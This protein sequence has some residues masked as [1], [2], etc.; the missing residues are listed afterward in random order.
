[1][2]ASELLVLGDVHQWRVA[3]RG[4]VININP[5]QVSS[6]VCHIPGTFH[7]VCA[8]IRAI[9]QDNMTAPKLLIEKLRPKEVKPLVQGYTAH[10]WQNRASLPNP[11]AFRSAVYSLHLKAF[12][13]FLFHVGSLRCSTFLVLENFN[14]Y[15]KD[16]LKPYLHL[17]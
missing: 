2:D 8:S 10:T 14:S 5:L 13:I 4:T 15:K 3:P 12:C 17:L 11:S 6:S 16:S 1:M 9:F 7:P